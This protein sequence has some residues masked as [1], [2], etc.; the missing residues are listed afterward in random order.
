MHSL[1]LRV[2]CRGVRGKHRK[3]KSDHRSAAR[4]AGDSQAGIRL[5]GKAAQLTNAAAMRPHWQFMQRPK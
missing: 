3:R 2:W 5:A 1:L 4:T